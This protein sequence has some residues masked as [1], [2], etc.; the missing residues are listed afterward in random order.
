MTQIKEKG[1]GGGA[2]FLVFDDHKTCYNALN[3]YTQYVLKP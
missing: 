3:V 1:K 2:F